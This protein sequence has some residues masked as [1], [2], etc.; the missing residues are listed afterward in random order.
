MGAVVKRF[1]AW[2]S[3]RSRSSHRSLRCPGDGEAPRVEAL[4]S[5]KSPKDPGAIEKLVERLAPLA[6]I[7][8]HARRGP[9]GG[10]A[11]SLSMAKSAKPHMPHQKAGSPRLRCLPRV[12]WRVLDRPQAGQTSDVRRIAAT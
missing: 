9:H 5:L 7:V 2:G 1:G 3:L 12:S 4:T 11:T 8:G 10:D 6:T